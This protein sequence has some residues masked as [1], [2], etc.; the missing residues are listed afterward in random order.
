[1]IACSARSP[2]RANQI[3]PTQEQPQQVEPTGDQQPQLKPQTLGA[4]EPQLN[5]QGNG[6]SAGTSSDV[7]QPVDPLPLPLPPPP[8]LPGSR[9][10]SME[11]PPQ[12]AASIE[13]PRPAPRCSSRSPS[14]P[15]GATSSRRFRA[16]RTT[17][18]RP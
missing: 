12:A 16:K 3:V 2:S 11:R 6:G 1:M 15:P 10:V 4:A 17:R 18:Q 5:A 8:A 13:R 7:N 9:E 14:P